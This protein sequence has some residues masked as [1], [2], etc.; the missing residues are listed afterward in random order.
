MMNNPSEQQWISQQA[1]ASRITINSY[2]KLRFN[3]FRELSGNREALKVCKNFS[4]LYF[5]DKPIGRYPFILL[6]GPPGIGKTHLCH[7]V[8]WSLIERGVAVRYYQAEE[9]LDDLRAGFDNGVYD[10]RVKEIK[11]VPLLIVDD[12]GAQA[13]T[14]WGM[15]KLDMI[16]DARYRAELPLII[17][18]NDLNIPPRIVDRLKEGWCVQ[19]TGESQRGKYG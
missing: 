4:I 11:K 16:V 17:T 9:L 5:G 7:A 19:M 13:D 15:A 14:P 3:T 18:S 1:F 8:A 6:Y 10:R 2:V 12:A